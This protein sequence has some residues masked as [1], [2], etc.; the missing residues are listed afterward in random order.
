VER[1]GERR[2]RIYDAAVVAD[3]NAKLSIFATRPAIYTP[4]FNFL[5]EVMCT[6]AL[7][8]GAL[9]MYARRELLDPSGRAL[10]RSVEGMWV[11]FFVFVA[12][13]GLGGPTGIAANP[14]RDFSP[15]LAHALLPIPGK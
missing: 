4:V 10:F 8:F 7:V 9:M 11:G 6:A 12:I 15:R 1:F 5:T 3:Q 14:A 2:E 13:L